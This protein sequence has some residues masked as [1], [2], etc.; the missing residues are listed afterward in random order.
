M[1]MAGQFLSKPSAQVQIKNRRMFLEL[2]RRMSSRG[3]AGHRSKIP[4]Y[5]AQPDAT[6]SLTAADRHALSNRTLI[7]RDVKAFLSEIGGDPR[8]ARYWLTQFQKANVSQSP[9]FAV[10]EVSL[11]VGNKSYFGAAVAAVACLLVRQQTLT[12]L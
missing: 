2:Q 12:L 7:Y 10:I 1:I 3:D 5:L 4:A 9:A 11:S 6:G 8:E